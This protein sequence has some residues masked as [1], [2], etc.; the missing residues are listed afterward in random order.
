M[1]TEE[2]YQLAK[3]GLNDKD[4]SPEER[5]VL[6]QAVAEYENSQLKAA[7]SASVAAPAP[8]TPPAP[9][10]PTDHGFE[11]QKPSLD[12][13]FKNVQPNADRDWSL[14]NASKLKRFSA[15]TEYVSKSS[16][17]LSGIAQAAKGM[18]VDQVTGVTSSLYFEP[19]EEQFVVDIG[20][21]LKAK[22]IPPGT[23]AYKQAFARYQDAKWE[24]AYKK[25]EAEDRTITR[26]D[27]TREKGWKKLANYLGEKVDV[28]A[29]FSEGIARGMGGPAREIGVAVRDKVTGRDD[30]SAM[31]ERA[32][33]SPIASGVGQVIGSA[34]SFGPFAKI[35]GRV[36]KGAGPLIAKTPLLNRLGP[37]VGR[38]LA[39][40]VGAAAGAESELVANT[41]GEGIADTIHN[42]PINPDTKDGFIARLIQTGLIG[43]VG[44]MVGE[45]VS[46]VA[47]AYRSH[48]RSTGDSLHPELANVEEGGTT[49]DMLR[50][51]DE[52]SSVK[53]SLERTRGNVPG[54]GRAPVMGKAVEYAA[55]DVVGPIVDRYFKEHHDTLSRI[56]GESMHMVGSHP[57]LRVPKTVENLLD[58]LR[59]HL[60]VRSQPEAGGKFIQNRSDA[61]GTYN[62]NELRRFV[63]RAM[64]PRIALAADA[65]G[66]AERTRGTVMSVNDAR[67]MG[68]KVRNPNKQAGLEST[69]P[70]SREPPA[71]DTLPPPPA[72][73]FAPISES[74][75]EEG[76]GG[77]LP[78]FPDTI[79]TRGA[80]SDWAEQTLPSPS[81]DS[82][83]ANASHPPLEIMKGTPEDAWVVI[84]EPRKYD[85]LAMES[86]KKSI[87]DAAGIAKKT[88]SKNEMW[89]DLVKAI[90]KDRDQFANGKWSELKNR[91]HD[92]LNALTQLRQHA[93]IYEVQPFTGMEGDTQ[94]KAT[95]A[96]TR[97]GIEPKATNE[98][99]AALADRAE[100]R[101]GLE[102]LK[103]TR[104]YTA[105]KTNPSQS[106][107][108]A[109]F[110][111]VGGLIPGAKL[112]GDAFARALAR[113]PE[114]EPIVIK[115][116][117]Q[118]WSRAH[119]ANEPVGRSLLPSSGLLAMGGGAL[120]LK[121]GAAID[122]TT[123]TAHPAGSLDPEQQRIISEY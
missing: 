95:A 110:P 107:L 68:F 86:L 105:L 74:E 23:E 64:K 56:D 41:L 42:R 51:L 99:I 76:I 38:Y 102:N 52:S 120:G 22:N 44:G 59:Y 2:E 66:I 45:G 100:V 9:V 28:G 30:V 32:N 47:R 114:G 113:N 65:K 90:R 25:A 46:D 118:E 93:G 94:K 6:N 48:I 79:P 14:P 119:L 1:I 8:P 55:D 116:L 15:P 83:P 33:R 101:P 69:P 19:T 84:V 43:G 77:G 53:Q 3:E 11:Q 26:V 122:S 4:V 70:L 21:Y 67:R 88:G 18:M 36:A 29:A 72:D 13:Q 81:A 37:T 115:G 80:P 34:A 12:E 96:I 17:A 63:L 117:N 54:E 91:H 57:D 104:A 98:A 109:S 73:E 58:M 49:T 20:P 16:P 123:N 82:V 85:A 71:N 7:A 97:Y 5:A 112:R 60:V 75:I 35:A 92:E 78:D 111:V 24:Q 87:D 50:G 89:D 31:R 27:Y 61:I 121:T 10:A 62:N 40:G 103:G 108:A 39:S 106:S